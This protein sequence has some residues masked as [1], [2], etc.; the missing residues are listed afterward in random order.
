M[1]FKTKLI[2]GIS[3]SFMLANAANAEL[4]DNSSRSLTVTNVT[5]S[6]QKIKVNE[7]DRTKAQGIS[8][9]RYTFPKEIEE[10]Y[11]AMTT[12]ID[13][14]ASTVNFSDNYIHIHQFQCLPDGTSKPLETYTYEMEPSSSSMGL[15]RKDGSHYSELQFISFEPQKS[16]IMHQS[17]VANL[18]LKRAMPDGVNLQYVFTPKLKPACPSYK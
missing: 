17:F 9:Q 10:G 12:S 18:E 14:I 5:Q 4:I 1:N 11:W 6:S 16:L 15:K 2:V 13:G 3:V 8:N 7:A